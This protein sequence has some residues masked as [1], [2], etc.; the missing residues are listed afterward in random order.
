MSIQNKTETGMSFVELMIAG[1]LLLIVALIASTTFMGSSQ[2]IIKSWDESVAVAR[3]QELL[4]EVKGMR[5]EYIHQAVGTG[6]PQL[7]YHI[8]LNVM[9]PV[10]MPSGSTTTGVPVRIV[11]HTTDDYVAMGYNLGAVT[12]K[13]EHEG[14]S[15]TESIQGGFGITVATITLTTNG[16]ITQ[17]LF[18]TLSIDGTTVSQRIMLFPSQGE[19]ISDKDM[20][21]TITMGASFVDDP[22]D[23]TPTPDIFPEDYKQIT[24]TT[25]WGKQGSKRGERQLATIIAPKPA[26]YYHP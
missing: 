1:L 26:T 25:S 9:N 2:T 22:A 6:T 21:G 19:T 8:H 23:N 12:L 11:A 16:T 18:G 17:R 24:I 7:P 5:Y 15:G 20:I 14:I 13:W 3:A 4:E 10:I